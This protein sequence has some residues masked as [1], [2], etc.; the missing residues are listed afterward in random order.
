MH[1]VIPGLYNPLAYIA[2]GGLAQRWF[3]DQFYN[4]NRGKLLPTD[5]DLY[6]KM[7][8]S[9]AKILP[10][11]DGLYFLPHMG[12]RICPSDPKMRGVWMGFSWGHTQ[13]HFFRAILE[14]VAYEYAYYLDIL[15]RLVPGI[16]LVST[17]VT[18][19]GASSELWNQIKADVLNV[20]YQRM[21][22]S[23][24]GT[25]GCAI[26]AGKAAGVYMDLVATAL[27][28]SSRL[29]HALEPNASIHALYQPYVKRYIQLE[30]SLSSVFNE[31][32]N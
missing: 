16:K 5:E 26:V 14:G 21:Q 22:R 8:A 30:K 3:R 23:E 2:G 1:S 31:L 17:R 13:A 29:G 6:N 12:G 28:Y 27:E 24:F 4:T 10:G 32:E 18:G 25:W 15:K 9:A 19:G 7:A 11:A 20:P